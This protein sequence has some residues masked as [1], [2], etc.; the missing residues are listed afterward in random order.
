VDDGGG[1]FQAVW[2]EVTG[3]PTGTGVRDADFFYFDPDTSWDAE[4]VVI[5]RGAE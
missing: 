3:R 4:D 5:P 1:V 2:K